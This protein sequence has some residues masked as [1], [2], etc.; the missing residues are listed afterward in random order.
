[1]GQGL[2]EAAGW[3]FASPELAARLRLPQHRAVELV[4]PMS[5]SEAEL[6]TTL[7]GSLLEILARNRSRGVHTVRLFEVGNAYLA[8]PG[9]LPR[10]PERIG[11][12]LSGPVRPPTWREQVPQQSDFF[13]AKGALAALLDFFQAPWAVEVA[14]E[15]FL[16]P[17]RA[18]SVV[19][20]G[21]RAGWLGEIHPLVLAE[22]GLEGTVAG[23]EVDLDPIYEAANIVP[24]YVDLVTFPAVREDLAVVVPDSVAAQ[25]VEETMVAAGAPLLARA[26]LF[27]TYRDPDQVGPNS[28]SLAFHL[29]FRAPDRTLTDDEVAG[30]RAAIRDALRERLGGNV[31]E[32]G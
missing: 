9:R 31:R 3:S 10:E 4:N 19:V 22:W 20:G 29:E 7:L 32:A 15:P 8:G 24:Q 30:M 17:G 18:A 11:A 12:L 23:F 2:H 27:D 25:Q 26:E 5:S 28:I 14:Q 21:Q 13:A 16:H 1:V 6:R